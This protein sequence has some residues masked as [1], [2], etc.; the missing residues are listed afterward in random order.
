VLV[1]NL[2]DRRINAFNATT[3]SFIG[4]LT[5]PQGKII[6]ESGLGGIAFGGGT[7]QNGR[8][9]QL[10]FASGPANEKAGPFGAISYKK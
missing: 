4:S 8:T 5:T 1:G 3:G 10:F 6:S 7:S 2:R 9:N